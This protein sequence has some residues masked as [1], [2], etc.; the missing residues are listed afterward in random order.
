MVLFG[1]LAVPCQRFLP[2]RFDSMASLIIDQSQRVLGVRISLPGCL[3]EPFGRLPIIF[4]DGISI[5]IQC[6]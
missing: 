1:S 5:K 6:S 4:L 2:V 3:E